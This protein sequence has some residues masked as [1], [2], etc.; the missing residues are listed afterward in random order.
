MAFPWVEMCPPFD[1]F[2][3]FVSLSVNFPVRG[4][5]NRRLASHKPFLVPWALGIT[6]LL[7]AS[8]FLSAQ[9]INVGPINVATQPS[10]G[11]GHDYIH[12]LDE[13][14]NPANG[15]VSV[16]VEAPVPQQRGD[17]NFPYYIFGY[18]SSGVS[19]PTGN[20]YWAGANG[21]ASPNFIIGHGFECVAEVFLAIKRTPDVFLFKSSRSNPVQAPH[22]P[23]VLVSDLMPR[24]A[25]QYPGFDCNVLSNCFPKRASTGLMICV[26]SSV[27]TL[28][29]LELRRWISAS[30]TK[31]NIRNTQSPRLAFQESSLLASESTSERRGWWNS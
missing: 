5:A 24:T 11:S 14:V 16:R 9:T 12:M 3:H 17:V 19:L 21:A 22:I 25:L 31:T 6:A 8:V 18:D 23:I 4:Q 15:S 30:G 1:S 2:Q 13:T 7:L 10:P 29:S 27:R 28:G 26:V 20:L